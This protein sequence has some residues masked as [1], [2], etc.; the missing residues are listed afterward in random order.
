MKTQKISF[1]LTQ[2]FSFNLKL[3]FFF[4]PFCIWASERRPRDHDW[5][6]ALRLGQPAVEPDGSDF[7][8]CLTVW[9]RRRRETT[10]I[11]NPEVNSEPSRSDRRNRMFC[12]HHETVRT[13]RNQLNGSGP[14]QGPVLVRRR[15]PRWNGSGWFWSTGSSVFF[16]GFWYYSKGTYYRTRT[17]NTSSL[18]NLLVFWKTGRD[19]TASWWVRPLKPANQN[20]SGCGSLKRHRQTFGSDR[21]QR[22]RIL[23]LI[24][25]VC[26]GVKRPITAPAVW[27]PVQVLLQS[28]DRKSS[29]WFK[30]LI[31]SHIY[32]F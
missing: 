20:R 8:F 30:C 29:F 31:C 5:P 4:L 24:K 23:P 16:S 13:N 27:T 10:Q 28:A 17:P 22:Q 19:P 2:M 14:F 1:F 7:C 6:P 26:N 32:G 3:I 9:R 12:W 18:Q 15:G 25:A 11:Q 21:F